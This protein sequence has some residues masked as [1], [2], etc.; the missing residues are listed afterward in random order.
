MAMITPTWIQLAT[1]LRRGYWTACSSSEMAFASFAPTFV[2]FG[3]SFIG[4]AVVRQPFPAVRD[5]DRFGSCV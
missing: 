1:I 4:A 5:L 2:A 3:M